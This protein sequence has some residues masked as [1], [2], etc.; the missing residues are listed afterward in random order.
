[1]N[2]DKADRYKDGGGGLQDRDFPEVR[3]SL[4]SEMALNMNKINLFPNPSTT[5]F[6]RNDLL[7]DNNGI[8]K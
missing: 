5:W 2:W 7:L 1:M 3:F 6:P 4:N 8:D